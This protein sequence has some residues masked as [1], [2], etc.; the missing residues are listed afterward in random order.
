MK[1]PRPGPPV[2]WLL[3]WLAVKILQHLARTGPIPLRPLTA[4]RDGDGG[5]SERAAAEPA[6]WT[7]FV[8]NPL[9][10]RPA[11]SAARRSRC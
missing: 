10:P 9:P 3:A 11:L 5:G 1:S 2:R 7:Y 6:F 4:P 8:P